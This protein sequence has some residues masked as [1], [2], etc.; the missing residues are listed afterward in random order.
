MD[1]KEGDHVKKG[2]LLATIDNGTLRAGLEQAEARLE[3]AR[4]ELALIERGASPKEIADLEHQ[5]G[6]AERAREKAR[7]EVSALRR[8][9]GKQA[10]TG[11][12]LTGAEI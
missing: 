1:V 11:A 6:V 3:S 4:A 12:E 10:A 5:L 9:A 8:L 7:R 2:S